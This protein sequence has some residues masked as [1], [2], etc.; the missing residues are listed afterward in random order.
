VTLI[1]LLEIGLGPLWV[2][3]VLSEVPAGA[4]VLGGALVLATIVV[5]SRLMAQESRGQ[6]A[7]AAQG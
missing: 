3:L 1:M 2:W 4:T 7:R 6:A 5:H